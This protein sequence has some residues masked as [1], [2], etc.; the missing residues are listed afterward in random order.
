MTSIRSRKDPK[1]SLPTQTLGD[2]LDRFTILTRKIYFGME[3]AISEHRYLEKGLSSW[4]VD[5]KL[6]T[7]IVRLAMMNFE[8]WNLEHEIRHGGEDKFSLEEIGRRA[9]AIRDLNR[10]RI[11]YKNKINELAGHF[12]ECKVRHRSQ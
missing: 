1:P 2:V 5:G 9:V 7:H 11:E 3:D 6:V 12:R 8:I 4:G 10:K